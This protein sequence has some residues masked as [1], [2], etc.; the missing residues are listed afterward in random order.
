MIQPGQIYRHCDPRESIRVRIAAYR[1]GDT[2]AEVVDAVTGKRPRRILVKDLH[3]SPVTA[4]GRRRRSGYVL[5]RDALKTPQEAVDGSQGASEGVSGQR[6]APDPFNEPQ[7]GAEGLGNDQHPR[8]PVDWARQQAA[9]RE[10][11]HATGDLQQQIT[12][13]IRDT[14]ARYPDD[15]ATAVMAAPGMKRLIA[16]AARR[17]PPITEPERLADTITRVRTLA[18]ELFVAGATDTHRSIG[19]R[20]L[21]ALQPPV[22]GGDGPSVSEAAAQDRRWWDSEKVGE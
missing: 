20:L 4:T 10:K 5:D 11:Q 2:R 22:P 18:A 8:G 1:P 7:T 12:A 14:P 16:Q 19:R 3:E 15:I 6:E 9:Q 13:A 17:E 21:N